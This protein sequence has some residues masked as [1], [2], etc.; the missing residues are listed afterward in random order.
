[1]DTISVVACAED[2][3]AKNLVLLLMESPRLLVFGRCLK[4]GQSAKE[5]EVA[6]VSYLLA[7]EALRYGFGNRY[8]RAAPEKRV[9]RE[10]L[11]PELKLAGRVVFVKSP[12]EM[13]RTELKRFN[14]S[15]ESSVQ[16]C[17]S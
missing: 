2:R 6:I 4:P 9:R 15:L 3:I 14:E 7:M 1:M 12:E 10:N 5:N 8:T 13:T 17:A 16:A 11:P